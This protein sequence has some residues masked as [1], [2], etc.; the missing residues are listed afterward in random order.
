MCSLWAHLAVISQEYAAYL[1]DIRGISKPYDYGYD[2]GLWTTPRDV[3]AIRIRTRKPSGKLF[4]KTCP[5]SAVLGR[6]IGV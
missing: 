5:I 3:I 6:I 1:Q 2:Y 4:R